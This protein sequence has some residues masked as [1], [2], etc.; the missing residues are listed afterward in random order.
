M[1]RI[2]MLLTTDL[3][4]APL[5]EA[6]EDFDFIK[7]IRLNIDRWLEYFNKYPEH[8]ITTVEKFLNNL[9]FETVLVLP[10]PLMDQTVRVLTDRYSDW[11]LGKIYKR[12]D[13][14]VNKFDINQRLILIEALNQALKIFKSKNVTNKN[15]K[16]WLIQDHDFKYILKGGDKYVL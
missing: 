4:K 7:Y 11:Y 9:S 16:E 8:N 15:F 13:S 12:L 14:F 1:I 5:I 10:D 2:K 3:I 6:D